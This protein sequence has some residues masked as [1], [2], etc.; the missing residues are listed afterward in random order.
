M[1]EPR[2][3]DPDD[4]PD[5]PGDSRLSDECRDAT[6]SPLIKAAIIRRRAG[7]FASEAIAGA[8]HA[9]IENDGALFKGPSRGNPV[10]VWS[11]LGGWQAYTGADR[12][13]EIEWGTLIG[14]AALALMHERARGQ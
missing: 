1:S 3:G 5:I 4:Y 10:E 6:R 12:P 11:P 7:K 8:G 14:P 13:R 2:H 9:L